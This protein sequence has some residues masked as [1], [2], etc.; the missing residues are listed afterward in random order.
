MK[1]IQLIRFIICHTAFLLLIN[2]PCFSQSNTVEFYV[3]GLKVI[4]RQ[5]QKE[6]VAMGMYFRGGASN[7]TAENAGI[8]SLALSAV[9]ECGTANY[10]PNDFHDEVDEYGLHLSADAEQ[11]YGRVKL[12]CI[13]AYFNEAWALFSAAITSPSFDPERFGLLKEKMINDLNIEQ[14]VP[15]NRLERLARETAFAGTP[16]ALNPDGTAAVLQSLSRDAVKNYYYNTLFN[17][18]RMFLV[19]AG[20]ITRQN[21]EQKV[22]AAF[23]SIPE[24]PYE[25]ATIENKLFEQ[26]S[27]K[28]EA[29]PL[30]T[31]YVAGILNAPSPADNDYPAFRLATSL[32]NSGMFQVIRVEKHLS[33]APSASLSEGKI[34]YV[35]M[36][37]STSDP[38]EAVKI[39]R[40]LLGY[41]KN[42]KNNATLVQDLKRGRWLTYI[43]GQEVMA[44]IVDNLGNAEV[45]GDWR[46]AENLTT[47]MIT[48]TPEDMNTVYKKYARHIKWAYIG[49]ADAGEKTFK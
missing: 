9:T 37:A 1:I 13:S 23:A 43:K 20:N 41:V 45:L 16:Y 47:R 48:V 35:K 4:L 42:Y 44:D 27:Y 28:I 10:A 46:L 49:N 12:T 21:L 15:D 17:K 3:N 39:M 31:N 40:N 38:K 29:S 2:V 19:V 33:Y 22:Q 18:K 34:S 26:E 6:T 5:T 24:K 8:E 7:Y 32:L 14:S 30:A 25:P 36:Y 11:D